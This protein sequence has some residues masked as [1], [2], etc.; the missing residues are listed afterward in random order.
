MQKLPALGAIRE[1]PGGKLIYLNDKGA[2][3]LG[4]DTIEDAEALLNKNGFRGDVSMALPTGL[5]KWESASGES[6]YSH[7]ECASMQYEGKD[8]ELIRLS[9]PIADAGN[10]DVEQM[11]IQRTQKLQAALEAME[12]TRDA[13]T[14]ALDKEKDLGELK[15]RFVSMASHEFRTPLSTILS[16]AFLAKQYDAEHQQEKR[17]KHLDR[18]VA[19]VSF[20]TDILNDFLSLGKIEEGKIVVRP[21]L[22]DV[23]EH[24]KTMIQEAQGIVKPHQEL[25]YKHEGWPDV[26]LDPTLL[27][28]IVLNLIGNAIKFS[29]KEHSVIEV[30]THTDSYGLTLKVRDNGIGMS[31]EDQAHLFERFFRGANVSNIQGTGLG[32]HIVAK[33]T[34]LMKG[35]ISCD[36]TLDVGTTFTIIFPPISEF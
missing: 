26:M 11:V 31:A 24:V 21:V 2:A 3:M 27:R 29:T 1:V 28:H 17:H 25:V 32:L 35:V 10:K 7:Y 19:S 15:S 18:I 5:R 6:F 12:T 36:S 33:Y 14:L 20:L 13:L 8:Y 22:F 4:V 34:E 30:I 23:R 16:S 9:T